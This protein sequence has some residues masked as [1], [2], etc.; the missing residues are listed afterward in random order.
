[1]N[2]NE[3]IR[4]K[5]NP[6]LIPQVSF[7]IE[8]FVF[9]AKSFYQRVGFLAPVFCLFII[10][11]GL[12]SY[13]EIQIKDSICLCTNSNEFNNC[14]ELQ[15]ILKK[16]NSK[17]YKVN[18]QK[19]LD[20][21]G[22]TYAK[23]D[24][25][26]TR[27]TPGKRAV[28]SAEVIDS[29]DPV[30]CKKIEKLQFPHYF[31]YGMIQNRARYINRLCTENGYPFA[32]VTFTIKKNNTSS[33]CDT[34]ELLY[35]INYDSKSVFGMPVFRGNG[36]V[37]EKIVAKDIRFAKGD[38]F[39]IRKVEESV[40]RLKS[41]SYISNIRWA[42][43][44]I[45]PDSINSDSSL[46]VTV[47]FICEN[48][49]GLGFDGAVGLFTEKSSKPQ[50]QGKAEF[51]LLNM[52]HTGEAATFLYA[53]DK[54]RQ[55]F[56]GGISKPWL[57]N[58][59]VHGGANFGLE[60]ETGLYGYFYGKLKVMGELSRFWDAGFGISYNET[61]TQTDS[62]GKNGSFYGFELLLSRKY[63]FYTMGEFSKE[64]SLSVG[65][66]VAKKEKNYNRSQISFALGGHIPF[67]SKQ[68]VAV[69]LVSDYLV[70]NEENLLPVELNRIGGY[71]S[72]RGYTDNEFSFKTDIYGQFEL[73]HYFN[74]SGSVF[75]FLDGGY[76]LT[77]LQTDRNDTYQ[78]M[79]GYGAGIRIPS[80]IG[81]MTLEWARNYSDKRN[82]GRIHI[83]FQNE[84]SRNI[85]KL[86]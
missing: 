83:R 55:Q 33:E 11:S 36:K 50:F 40:E 57:F 66:G 3:H 26:N 27:V 18:I 12:N 47:P 37:S 60:I 49:S 38:V 14:K 80:K 31:D 7:P 41:R 43:P 15:A 77:G 51:S 52:F 5:S 76:G 62:I 46:F 45:V 32:S 75:I 30:L 6:L 21:T 23:W 72:I 56:D 68:A 64:F 79:L 9:L 65:S 54:K 28:V 29:L 58:L 74:K 19:F 22:F 10:I 25:V 42:D 71:N 53:G 17:N 35:I 81:L 8:L 78:K 20:S 82:P 73:L 44:M 61:S 85:G 16:Q 59:P 2:N 86:L 34:F 69:R 1:M 63:E 48:N 24:S 13:A 84:I 4:N 67:L 39:D 70:T